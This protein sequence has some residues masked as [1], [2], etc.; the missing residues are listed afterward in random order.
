M[1]FGDAVSVRLGDAATQP[2]GDVRDPPLWLG[3]VVGP[4]SVT[5]PVGA[6]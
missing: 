2:R 3:P 6:G 5:P 1:S 4:R